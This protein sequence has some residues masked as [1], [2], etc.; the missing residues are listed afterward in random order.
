MKNEKNFLIPPTSKKFFRSLWE[1]VKGTFS[2]PG[3]FKQKGG[4][5]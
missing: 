4:K 1:P 3:A 2:K 5:N